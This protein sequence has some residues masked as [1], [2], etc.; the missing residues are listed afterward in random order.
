MALWTIRTA[1][2]SVSG[3]S[4]FELLY[5]REDLLP[6]EIT[7]LDS[8]EEFVE[9]SIDEVLIERILEYTKWVKDAA[10]KKLGSINYWKTRRK[11]KRSMEELPEYKIGDKVKIIISKTKIGPILYWPLYDKG[12][13][14]EYGETTGR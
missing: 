7:L 13:N 2:S 8:L 14:L 3:Y 5:G 10:N 12:N 4:S 6:F 9:C 1:K 11:A